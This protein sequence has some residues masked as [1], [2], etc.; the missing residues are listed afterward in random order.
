MV[1]DNN[2]IEL[3]QEG[4]KEIISRFRNN[5]ALSQCTSCKALTNPKKSPVIVTSP[6]GVNIRD[7]PCISGNEIASLGKGA[8]FNPEKDCVG[9]C[10]SDGAITNIWLRVGVKGG[11]TGFIWSGATDYPFTPCGANA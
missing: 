7:K 2:D 6:N 9:Q 1:E 10:V 11:K 8:K 5:N 4:V 3:E